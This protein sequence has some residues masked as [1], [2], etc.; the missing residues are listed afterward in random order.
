[1]FSIHKFLFSTCRKNYA[2]LK[3]S[4]TCETLRVS[5]GAATQILELTTASIGRDVMRRQRKK[6]LN[7]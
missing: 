7:K 2:D 4:S 6:I 5:F 3:F 1:M